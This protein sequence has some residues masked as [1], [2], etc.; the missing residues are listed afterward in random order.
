[1]QLIVHL[2]SVIGFCFLRSVPPAVLVV[3]TAVVNPLN[4]VSATDRA[5]QDI[6]FRYIA[7]LYGREHQ[8]ITVILLDDDFVDAIDSSWPVPHRTMT[9]FLK[10][11]YC[12]GPSGIFFDLLFTHEHSSE[13]Q[14]DQLIDYL[15]P[16]QDVQ[17]KIVQQCAK[18]LVDRSRYDDD[19]DAYQAALS[20]EA[21]RLEAE[22]LPLPPAYIGDLAP[23]A[24]Y[25][26]D[27]GSAVFEKLIEANVRRLPTN[28]VGED[29]AYPLV[30][31]LN[32]AAAFGAAGSDNDRDVWRR[33]WPE[34]IEGKIPSSAL[35][36][37]ATLNDEVDLETL[38]EEQQ[39]Q[40]IVEWGFYPRHLPKEA[41]TADEHDN[42]SIRNDFLR[43]RRF[44]EGCH[45]R[46]DELSW[47]ALQPLAKLKESVWQFL[48]DT[49]GF[50][51]SN[52]DQPRQTCPYTQWIPGEAVLFAD[53]AAQQETLRALFEDRVVMIGAD[54]KGAP[55]LIQTPVHGQIPGVFLHAM[56]LDNLL[57]RGVNGYWRPMPTLPERSYLPAIVSQQSFSVAIEMMLLWTIFAFSSLINL[58]RIR[59]GA[60]WSEGVYSGAELLGHVAL[61]FGTVATL[62]AYA[63]APM[64]W[65]GL[66]ALAVSK[67]ILQRFQLPKFDVGSVLRLR[68][69]FTP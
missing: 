35:A 53:G 46:P 25:P 1:M 67:D 26:V 66:V 54:I 19:S 47:S 37:Y 31:E 32:R 11:L 44:P 16:D 12:Y 36:L 8:P 51:N 34:H 3:A 56:A 42:E 38:I 59:A 15:T 50:L 14:T 29:G 30:I 2:L 20:K 61:V 39:K 21:T 60:R 28:W 13:R 22:L 49:I 43:L 27:G 33:T 41:M 57:E 6:F 62:A 10:T 4:V 23:Q 63:I 40:L 7:P 24:S 55:D 64:N 18:P 69:K 45:V 48:Q 9:N 68:S 58:W 52:P 65:L 17:Q 5:S